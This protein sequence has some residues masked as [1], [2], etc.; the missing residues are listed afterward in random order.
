VQAVCGFKVLS[1][2][3]LS[4]QAE[5]APKASGTL[6]SHYAPRAP[7]HLVEASKLQAALAQALSGATPTLAVWSQQPP[8]N[9]QPGVLWRAM[10][11][12]ATLAAQ[13]LF[14]VLRAFDDQGVSD[15]W[16]ESPP[17]APDWAGVRDRLQRAA[18]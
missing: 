12:D 15:I 11:A 6:E 1:K 18:C 2:E 16:I 14:A 5:R 17:D 9:A 8:A 13:Q 10:P 3:E 4:S 7:V